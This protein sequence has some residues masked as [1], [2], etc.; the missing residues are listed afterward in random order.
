MP[1]I[2][3]LFPPGVTNF[4]DSHNRQFAAGADGTIAVDP[5][6]T[7]VNELLRIGCVPVTN[8]YGPTSARPNPAPLGALHFDTDLGKPVFLAATGWVDSTGAAV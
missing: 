5:A 4:S 8:T 6:T 1:S 2:R 3:L 7:N